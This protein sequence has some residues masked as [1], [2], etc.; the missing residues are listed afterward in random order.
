VYKDGG[1]VRRR[2]SVLGIGVGEIDEGV[3]E[4]L[5][6]RRT[7]TDEETGERKAGRGRSLSGT[8]GDMWRGLRGQGDGEEESGV[9][10]ERNDD[11]S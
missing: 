3:G 5:D 8:L 2:Q 1:D 7:Q 10:V 4:P 6:R 11:R 9:D